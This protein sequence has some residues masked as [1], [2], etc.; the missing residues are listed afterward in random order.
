MRVNTWDIQTNVE[1]HRI[2]SALRLGG[3]MNAAYG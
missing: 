2:A 3:G 1:V